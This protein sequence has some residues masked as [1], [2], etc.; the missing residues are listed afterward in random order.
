MIS[1]TEMAV[2][3]TGHT[4]VAMPGWAPRMGEGAMWVLNDSKCSTPPKQWQLLRLSTSVCLCCFCLSAEIHSEGEQYGFPLQEG[5]PGTRKNWCGGIWL[6]LQVHQTPWWMCL[7]HQTLQKASG[8]ILWWVSV[9]AGI[10]QLKWWAC[11]WEAWWE[12]GSVDLKVSDGCHEQKLATAA[13]K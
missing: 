3:R 7:C 2:S 8:R 13:H 9:L 1:R 11:S 5:V 12:G 6:C 10:C 4:P